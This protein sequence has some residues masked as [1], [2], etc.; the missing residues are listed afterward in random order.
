MNKKKIPS[1]KILGLVAIAIVLSLYFLWPGQKRED[2]ATESDICKVVREDIASKIRQGGTIEALKTVT[3]SSGINGK[4]NEVLVKDGDF[5]KKGQ[6]LIRFREE[7]LLSKLE[8]ERSKYIK[9]KSRLEEVKGWQKS[10][11]F[12][13]AKT[14]L[15]TSRASCEDADNT[16]KQNQDLFKAKA[17]AK[18]DLD[19]SLLELTRARAALEG[20]QAQFEEAKVRGNAD[21]LKEAKAAFIADEIAFKDA[22]MALAQKDVKAPCSGVVSLRQPGA[23]GTTERAI[24]INRSVSPGE[25]LLTIAD[26]DRLCVDCKVDEFD[27][28]RIRLG[29]ECKIIIPALSGEAFAGRVVGIAPQTSDKGT[30]FLVRSEIEKP[31][32][33]LKVGISATVEITFEE[34]NG[35]LVVPL[36][37][38]VKRGGQLGVYLINGKKPRYTEVKIGLTDN[39][40]A[41]VVDGLSEGQEV[42]RRA[43]AKSVEEG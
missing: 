21:A 13:N 18:Q 39:D 32:A 17:I 27:I 15:E 28:Y 29:Q 20:A 40:V 7:D 6:V 1:K 36:T 10:S 33:L 4:I 5:V 37:A 9:S 42:L 8:T 23:T 3:V 19:K 12:I 41:E 26:H 35:V 31:S 2:L 34:R 16:Y 24:S 14:N 30:F 38:L 43:P 25:F 11:T 22:E